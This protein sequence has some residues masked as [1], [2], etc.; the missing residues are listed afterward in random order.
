ML[1]ALQTLGVEF[2]LEADDTI[3]TIKGMGTSF[4]LNGVYDL[5]LGN[6][7]T[8]FR[9]LVAALAFNDGE[10][11][12]TLHGQPRMHER[13]I[14]DLVDAL[15]DLGADISYLGNPGYPPLKITTKSHSLADFTKSVKIKG[16]ISSQY[17]TALLMVAPLLGY[18]LT[19]E[20]DGELISKPYIDI[21]LNTM[22]EF[23]VE[24]KN[25]DYQSFFI[26]PKPYTA[27][28]E[29]MVECDASSASYFLLAGAVSGDIRVYGISDKSIQGD[30]AFAQ[31]LQ[32]MGAEVAYGNNYIEAKAKESLILEELNNGKTSPLNPIVADLNHIPDAAMG[33][34][35]AAT[36]T[37][38]GSKTK[39]SGIA[40]WK[41]KETDRI[42][43]MATELRKFGVEVNTGDDFIEVTSH[44]TL[45]SGVEVETYNDHRIAMCFAL[46]SLNPKLEGDYFILD[47]KCVNKTFPTFFEL[48]ATIK[49]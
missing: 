15:R 9:P 41:V 20:I 31:V 5:E 49:N 4:K 44:A 48:F 35:I 26:Q 46:L 17:L 16:N 24:V 39:I 47:P 21:T 40:S 12:F 22:A 38:I 32:Q 23:G 11:E 1:G 25:K 34:A 33:I 13:P 7:G 19:I 45:K 28:P 30:V 29:F 43:S 14:G 2:K 36:F 18:A 42:E 3:C 8:A 10:A 27:V 6:A 37:P